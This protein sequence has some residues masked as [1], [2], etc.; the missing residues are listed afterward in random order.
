MASIDLVRSKNSF[1]GTVDR[2]GERLMT[3]HVD[4]GDNVGP[5]RGDGVLY[6]VKATLALGGGLQDDALLLAQRV[7]VHSDEVRPGF[8]SVVLGGTPHDPLDEFPV[9]EVLGA[10]YATS[11]MGEPR[12][13]GDSYGRA[14]IPKADFLPYHYGRLDDWSAHN[15]LD[16]LERT[17]LT[18]A[19]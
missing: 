14:V 18:P 3:L 17:N 12:P 19:R 2:M 7:E 15:A 5:A 13:I 16:Q 1:L 6:S 4:A 10:S 9:L 8:G 11:E